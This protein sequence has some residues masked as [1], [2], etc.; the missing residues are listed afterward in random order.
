MRKCAIGVWIAL[1]GVVRLFTGIKGNKGKYLTLQIRNRDFK[2]IFLY[3]LF[4]RNTKQLLQSDWSIFK[5][6][7]WSIKKNHIS[8]SQATVFVFI[9]IIKITHN[10]GRNLI[11]IQMAQTTSVLLVSIYIH[12]TCCALSPPPKQHDSKNLGHY[13]TLF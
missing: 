12:C 8:K 13:M 6:F 4:F 9:L 11:K 3:N 5:H 7:P 10:L 2:M 1:P